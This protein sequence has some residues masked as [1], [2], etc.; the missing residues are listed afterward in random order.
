MYIDEYNYM[1]I[2]LL[3][4]LIP[5]A[6][7]TF[8][9]LLKSFKKQ[10]NIKYIRIISICALIFG[11][12]G[13][14][15]NV[16][17]GYYFNN[18]ESDMLIRQSIGYIALFPSK[19]VYYKV[20]TEYGVLKSIDDNEYIEQSRVQ[21]EY[22]EAV[23]KESQQI[24][25]AA[26]YDVLNEYGNYYLVTLNNNIYFAVDNGNSGYSYL[27]YDNLTASVD[28]DFSPKFLSKSYT[29]GLTGLSLSGLEEIAAVD[30]YPELTDCVH[31]YET[32]QIKYGDIIISDERIVVCMIDNSE[33]YTANWILYEYDQSLKDF[34]LLCKTRSYTPEDIFFL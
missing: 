3:V 21:S 2:G 33:P 20:N 12:I 34:K 17:K 28:N 32:N 19:D 23:L 30:A 4:L 31:R 14:S 29:M 24:I 7:V 6:C 16:L 18:L 1:P 11:G 5:G 26:G 10:K 25:E 27:K 13:I 15:A 9:T 8:L 22:R